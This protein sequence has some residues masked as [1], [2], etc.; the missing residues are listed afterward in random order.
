MSKITGFRR[1][2][3]FYADLKE[4]NVENHIVCIISN[5]KNNIKSEFVNCVL[6]T[7]QLKNHPS[8]VD[9]E[10]FGLDK[11]SQIICENI[12]TVNK[13]NLLFKIG[14]IDD[15]YTQLEIEK[16]LL[17]QQQMS[18]NYIN[19]NIEDLENYLKKG[20]KTL[21][22]KSKIYKLKVKICDLAVEKKN[23][24]AIIVCDELLELLNDLDLNNH[25]SYWYAHYHKSLMFSRLGQYTLAESSARESLKYVGSLREGLNNF[26]A[27]SMWTLAYAL[28]Q[29]EYQKAIEI[30]ENLNRYYKKIGKMNL[31]L[32]MLFNIAR[33]QKNISKMDMLIKITETVDFTEFE[34]NKSKDEL[35][36]QMYLDLG[37]VTNAIS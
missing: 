1:F 37:K 36:K 31:R 2:D 18:S 22:N 29:T 6:I 27:Y 16:A 34:N 8:H 15:I 33:L 24:E 4:L 12:I 17:Q 14:N 7:S 11:L 35:L 21:D 28:E 30:Y 23:Q 19:A 9:I 26:Y 3:M 32:D 20:V 13:K 25:N 5:Y 10:G